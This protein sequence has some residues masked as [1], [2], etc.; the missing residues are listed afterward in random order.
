MGRGTE[1]VK[2]EWNGAKS[3]C[4]ERSAKERP[5]ALLSTLTWFGTRGVWAGTRGELCE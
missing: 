3:V 4:G 5:P 2:K 1:L